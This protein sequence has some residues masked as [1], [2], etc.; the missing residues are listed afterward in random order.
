VLT[1]GAGFRIQRCERVPTGPGDF[2]VRGFVDEEGLRLL[3]TSTN[4]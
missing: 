1:L 4:L 3:G 2:P